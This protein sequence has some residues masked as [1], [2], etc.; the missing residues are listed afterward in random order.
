MPKPWEN[1]SGCNDPTAYKVEK[2][3]SEDEQ[4]VSEL[5]YVLK[6]IIKWAGF[7]LINRIELRDRKSGR[8]YR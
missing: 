4:R 6:K 3:I 2:S 8:Q 1:K 5:V 7:E